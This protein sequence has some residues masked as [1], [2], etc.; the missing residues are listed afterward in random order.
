MGGENNRFTKMKEAEN[1]P[2]GQV[3]SGKIVKEKE[4]KEKIELSS[5]SFD[6]RISDAMTAYLQIKKRGVKKYDFTGEILKEKM[7]KLLKEIPIDTLKIMGIDT[8]F[9]K[10]K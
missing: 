8:E 6:R 1:L 2:V 7:M 3:G 9:F 4:I 10:L 5:A